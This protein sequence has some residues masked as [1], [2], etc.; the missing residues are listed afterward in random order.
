MRKSK[1]KNI[2]CRI[3]RSL[4][5]YPEGISYIEYFKR[6]NVYFKLN[7][8]LNNYIVTHNGKHGA[9]IKS[10]MLTDELVYEATFDQV[11]TDKSTFRRMIELTIINIRA[12]A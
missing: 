1:G 6:D 3:S 4:N 8:K 9:Y 11:A 10:G 7:F 5:C 12:N 2:K